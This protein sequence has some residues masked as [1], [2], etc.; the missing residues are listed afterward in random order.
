MPGDFFCQFLYGTI[1]DNGILAASAGASL[2]RIPDG[3]IDG[4]FRAYLLTF[5]IDTHFA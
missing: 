3:R 4:H 5:G 1:D 2:F